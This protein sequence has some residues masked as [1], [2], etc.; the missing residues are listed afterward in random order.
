MGQLVEERLCSIGEYGVALPDERMVYFQGR[1]EL[2][3]RCST[4]GNSAVQ[5]QA[6]GMELLLC[7]FKQGNNFL[8]AFPE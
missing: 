6:V 2:F 3:E 1:V 8:R 7:L 4:Y 5:K